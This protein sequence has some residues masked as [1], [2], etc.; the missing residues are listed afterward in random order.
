MGVTELTP[1]KRSEC[2]GQEAVKDRKWNFK[3]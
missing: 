1:W 3:H 2:K